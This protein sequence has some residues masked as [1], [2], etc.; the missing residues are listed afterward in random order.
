MA[1]VNHSTRFGSATDKQELGAKVGTF[2]RIQDI[3]KLIPTAPFSGYDPVALQ[4]NLYA[5][6]EAK[7]ALEAGGVIIVFPQDEAYDADVN[8]NATPISQTFAKLGM[9]SN[10]LI[11]PITTHGTNETF[12]LATGKTKANFTVGEVIDPTLAD[13]GNIS[14]IAQKTWGEVVKGRQKTQATTT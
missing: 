14:Q 2:T 9:K 4:L 6:Q 11:V 1:R 13:A 12:K 8:L 10:S 5:K 7:S 3:M